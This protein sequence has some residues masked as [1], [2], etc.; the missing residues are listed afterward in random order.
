MKI[1][2]ALIALTTTAAAQSFNVDVG[3]NLIIYPVPSA[4]YGG[5]A[6]QP[7]VWNASISPYSTSLVRLDGSASAVTTSSTATGAYGW[8]FGPITGDDY[9]LVADM[10]DLGSSMVPYTW[11]FS[12][13]QDGSYVVY[14]YAFA[15]D[16]TTARTRVSITGSSDPAQV[17]GGAWT[18]S[19]HALGITYALHHVTVSGGTLVVDVRSSTG[20]GSINGFQLVYTPSATPFCF[21][22]G[23][24][25]AC[26]C[27]NTGGAGR[28]CANSIQPAGGQLAGGGNVSVGND[29]LVLTGSGIPNGPGLYFQGTTQLGGGNGVLFGDGLRCTGGT[30][31]R[32]GVISAASNTSQYPR[33]G[34]DLSVSLKGLVAAGD[35][36]GY[37]LWY[38][39]SDASFC[40]SSV[41]NLTNAVSVTWTP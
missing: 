39:D 40:T 4:T 36:R 37:Q 12:N 17:V 18:G 1:L 25:T 28:G 27:A 31:I 26:P 21:G 15:P 16:S 3:A 30:V 2:A 38:R 34:L 13:L 24:G 10:Q 5:A 41:F 33:P 20:S 22:D 7:G 9:N 11:T 19:P 32:L 6:A 35:V 23:T 14:T 8:P 29:S